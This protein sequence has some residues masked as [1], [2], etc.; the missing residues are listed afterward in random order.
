MTRILGKFTHVLELEQTPGGMVH[1][2][3]RAVMPRKPGGSSTD[4]QN[5]SDTSP[6]SPMIRQLASAL[7]SEFGRR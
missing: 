5:R 1:S 2:A 6:N 3:H 4:A 7:L